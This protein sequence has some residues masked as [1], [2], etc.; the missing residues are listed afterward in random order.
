[1][2]SYYAVNAQFW[3][4]KQGQTC[5]ES[6]V[7]GISSSFIHTALVSR[8]FLDVPKIWMYKLYIQVFVTF[9]F[10]PWNQWRSMG[11]ALVS[12]I[13]FRCFIF[14]CYNISICKKEKLKDETSRK[15]VKPLEVK[16]RSKISHWPKVLHRYDYRA[17]IWKTRL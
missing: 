7:F 9:S 16:S 8:I 15:F 5:V 13:F 10:L 1:M 14:N 4:H 6:Q 11:P 17:I 2:N 12:R 3:N